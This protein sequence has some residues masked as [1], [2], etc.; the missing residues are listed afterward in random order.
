MGQWHSRLTADARALGQEH[1]DP[2]VPSPEGDDEARPLAC[3]AQPCPSCPARNAGRPL[4]PADPAEL[5]L[6]AHWKKARWGDANTSRIMCSALPADSVATR[7]ARWSPARIAFITS[8]GPPKA[9][10]GEASSWNS[11]RKAPGGVT[12]VGQPEL[13]TRHRLGY[14]KRPVTT[15]LGTGLS[16]PVL[17]S[18]SVTMAPGFG[19]G[20]SGLPCQ[21]CWGTSHLPVIDSPPV[22]KSHAGARATSISARSCR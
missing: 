9:R 2:G 21:D 19:K 6:A 16:Q 12:A 14:S 3:E 18:S 5:V 10:D 22:T 1:R 11:S 4:V 7:S 13:R 17:A 8:S 15:M 20:H